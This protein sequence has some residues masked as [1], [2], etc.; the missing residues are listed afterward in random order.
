[1]I[2]VLLVDDSPTFRATLMGVLDAHPDF[3]V[4]GSAFDGEQALDLVLRLK[5]DLVLMDLVMPRLG[6]IE[7]TRQIMRVAPCPI[8]LLSGQLRAREEGLVFE[9]L[10]AGAVDVLPKP[11]GLGQLEVQERFLRSLRMMASVKLTRRR[12]S[13]DAPRAGGREGPRLVAVGASTGGPPAI[14]RLLRSLDPDFPLPLAIAQHLAPG[15]AAGFRR[16][17][18]EAS[19]R[20]VQTVDR[21]LVPMPGQ[22]Y[23]A[24][25][26]F[27]LVWE[28]ERLC[29]ASAGAPSSFAMPSVDRLF[30]S[31]LPVAP[32]VLAV[33][34]TGMG[35][36][37]SQGLLKLRAAGAYTLVQDEPTSLV[38]G[39]PLAARELGAAAEELPLEQIGPRLAQLAGAGRTHG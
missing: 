17:L 1:M 19:G 28:G 3:G 15:F 24:A 11:L 8:V 23:L 33:L 20:G 31:L 13:P 22:V 26:G 16:W 32:G 36:D 29:P 37:G 12:S 4:L 6:G 21:P 2:R 38:H 9:A 7:A 14:C 39:M 10:N 18:G 25:D 30:E 27:H 35:T 5:P 34:L